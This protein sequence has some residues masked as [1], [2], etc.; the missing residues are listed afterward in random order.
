MASAVQHVHPKTHDPRQTM[1]FYI[2]DFGATLKA[3]IPGRGYR[4]DLPSWVVTQYHYG[5][6]ARIGKNV[7]VSSRKCRPATARGS[8]FSKR[9][10]ASRWIDPKV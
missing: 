6:L 2:D 7:C 4:L 3:E 1:H 9:P 5:P 8:A 10:T